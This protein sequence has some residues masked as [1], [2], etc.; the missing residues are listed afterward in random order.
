MTLARLSLQLPFTPPLD[1]AALL[2]HFA[3]RAVPGIERVGADGTYTRSL[4]LPRGAGV[5][6][7]RLGE[8]VPRRPLHG[9]LVLA[10]QRDAAAAQTLCRALLD[11]DSDPAPVT[12]QLG[13]DPLL[14]SAVTASPGRRVP[15]AAGA[16]ELCVRTILGQQISL[17]GAATAAGRLVSRF[18]AALGPLADGDVTHLFPAAGALAAADPDTLAMPRARA[19]SLVGLA[20][21]LATGDLVLERG[22]DAVAAR[23]QLLAL[24]GIGPWSADYIAMRVLGDHDIFL[25]G[26]LGVRRALERAGLPGD[27]RSAAA[28]AEH[29]RPIR[30]YAMQYLWTI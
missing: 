5:V 7:L 15:G 14:R 29:W 20:T 4:A 8:V 21:A 30:S 16:T 28:L 9:E 25:S 22:D 12:E 26:D 3:N 11:L 1:S 19:R 13:G 23:E 6:T 24:P 2:G 17:A 10:D 18:G 27:P